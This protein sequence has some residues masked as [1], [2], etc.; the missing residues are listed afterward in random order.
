VLLL[1][2]AAGAEA[3]TL[4]L[5]GGV[6]SYTAATGIANAFSVAVSGG[7]YTID[8]PAESAITLGA[9]ALAAGC[10]NVDANTV[11]CPRTS[12]TGWNLNLGDQ[13]DSASLAPVT[14]PATVRGGIGNDTLFGGAAADTFTWFPGDGSD[15]I[16]GG[17]GADTFNVTASNAIETFGVTPISGGFHFTRDVAAITMDVVS[18]EI[19]TLQALGGDDTVNTRGLAST[20]QSFDGGVQTSADVLNYDSAGACA[21]Q[22]ATTIQSIGSQ[23][24]TYSGFETVNVLN[25]CLVTPATLDIA[26][27]VLSYTAGFGVPN[28][29][30]V[31]LSASAYTID[32]ASEPAIALGSGAVAAGC[33]SLDLNTAV[34]PRSAI[35]SWNV[36]L[37][38]QSDSANLSAVLEPIT[39]RG[40]QGNDLLI[41]GANNDTF[42]WFPGDGSDTIEGGFGAD[43]LAFTGANISENIGVNA[44]PS[45]FQVTRDV[46]A[47]S[48]QVTGVEGLSLQLLGGDDTVTTRPLPF[49]SQTID[50]GTQAGGDTLSYDGGGTACTSQTPGSFQTG[51]N[52]PVTFTGFETVTLVGQCATP[53]PLPVTARV[54]MVALLGAAVTGRAGRRARL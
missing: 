47:I 18:V 17:P 7:S 31:S 8:D 41:G 22:T 43:V 12:V 25:S 2:F 20:S 48:L 54:L 32:D 39:I 38:D 21:T 45:G 16:D 42:L 27:G 3:A 46:A 4:D 13:N 14:E 36:S 5:A 51:G 30:A 19:L 28:A 34:C 49:T 15:F 50:A 53:V 29:L 6:L 40:G 10:V 1:S 11:S 24:V 33:F 23:P 52:A 9:G 35:G 44:L 26:S 37:G